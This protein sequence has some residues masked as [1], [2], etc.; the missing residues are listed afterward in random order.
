MSRLN[1]NI[2]ALCET[3]WENNKNFTRDQHRIMYG[4]EQ[5]NEILE[6]I[7]GQYMCSAILEIFER[8]LIFKL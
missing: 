4:S 2:L 3:R 7:L 5:K 6:L 1:I 8:I